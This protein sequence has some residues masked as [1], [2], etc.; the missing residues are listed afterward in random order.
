MRHLGT[1]IAELRDMRMQP[2]LEGALKR[3]EILKA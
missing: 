3:K 1:A 2:S